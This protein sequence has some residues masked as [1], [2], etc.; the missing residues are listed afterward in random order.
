M[1]VAGLSVSLLGALVYY[2]ARKREPAPATDSPVLDASDNATSSDDLSGDWR[3]VRVSVDGKIESDP[4]TLRFDGGKLSFPD[5]TEALV[6]LSLVYR[7]TT[8]RSPKWIDLEVRD[9]NDKEM[10]LSSRK[11]IFRLQD[12]ELTICTTHDPQSVEF[13]FC[14]VLP[15][16]GLA[17][18]TDFDPQG[19]DLFA[20]KRVSG[21]K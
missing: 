8:D 1:F 7:L 5:D 6:D 10:I 21:G 18:P 3:V 14:T 19:H 17:R 4:S 9:I 20:L 16:D 15:D 11:A 13:K 2:V 12:D